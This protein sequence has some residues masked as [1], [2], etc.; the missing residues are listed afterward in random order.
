MAGGRE[1]EINL[2]TKVCTHLEQL[3]SIHSATDTITRSINKYIT[4]AL[5]A[6]NQSKN[7]SMFLACPQL[8]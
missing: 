2:W 5:N 1:E 8:L 3:Q 7:A 4:R 6:E